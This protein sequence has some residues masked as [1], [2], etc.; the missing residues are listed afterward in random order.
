[1]WPWRTELLSLR[2]DIVTARGT[3]T[4]KRILES[5]SSARGRI[6]KSYA[7]LSRWRLGLGAG[8]AEIGLRNVTPEMKQKLALLCQVYP[9]YGNVTTP[10]VAKINAM[11][12]A[13]LLGLAAVAA[14]K[15]NIPL[16]TAGFPRAGHGGTATCPQCSASSLSQK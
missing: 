8:G 5:D 11:S 10:Y 2:A 1:M 14:A 9:R 3:L 6:S 7:P 15:C 16:L 13:A 4:K 12:L